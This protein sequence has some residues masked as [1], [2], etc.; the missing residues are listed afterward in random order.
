[1]RTFLNSKQKK[2]IEK[3]EKTR[4]GWLLKY[5]API[6]YRVIMD[7][8]KSGLP[9]AEMVELVSY[10]SL[11]PIFRTAQFRYALIDY[12]LYGLEAKKAREDIGDAEMRAIKTLYF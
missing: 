10:T 4:L 7:A 11:N 5:D 9:T 8:T 6:E 3:F 1:M 12:R 2:D